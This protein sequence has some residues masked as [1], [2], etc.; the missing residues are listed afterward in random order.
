MSLQTVHRTLIDNDSH[1]MATRLT[2]SAPRE[3]TEHQQTDMV[4]STPPSSALRALSPATA[5]GPV[6][7]I[8]GQESLFPPRALSPV[9]ASG[10][11]LM[12][13]SRS[14]GQLNVPPFLSNCYAYSSYLD[15]F[16]CGVLEIPDY[17]TDGRGRLIV[18]PGEAYCRIPNCDRGVSPFTRTTNL[19]AHLKTHG[20]ICSP[21][22]SGRLGMAQKE[23]AIRF[24]NSFFE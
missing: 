24:F 3:N 22:W 11:G 13:T 8:P 12:M 9:T 7:N 19:R 20:A 6:S 17:E 5:S 16:P 21:A 18:Y 15:L 1:I 4:D 10:P 14:T 23:A 2:I